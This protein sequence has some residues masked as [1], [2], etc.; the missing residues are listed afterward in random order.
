MTACA[1][2]GRLRNV[3]VFGTVSR[4]EVGE[5]GLYE[6]SV[7]WDA[8]ELALF[9]FVPKAAGGS[10]K[11]ESNWRTLLGLPVISVEAPGVGG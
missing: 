2:T 6:E 8:G 11:L 9:L 4:G 10:A 3:G 1:F 7:L 5:S